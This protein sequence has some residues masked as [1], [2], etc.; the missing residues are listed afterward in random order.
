VNWNWIPASAVAKAMSGRAGL[1]GKN[2]MGNKLPMLPTHPFP[3]KG[4][5]QEEDPFGCAQDKRGLWENISCKM[6]IVWL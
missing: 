6:G 1:N 5:H 2:R 3:G 4:C